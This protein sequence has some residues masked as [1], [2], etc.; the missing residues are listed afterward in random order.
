[1]N[2]Q[3][4]A[5][6]PSRAIL[7]LALMAA[8]ALGAGLPPAA[9]LSPPSSLACGLTQKTGCE[10]WT[11]RYNDTLNGQDWAYDALVSLDGS[12]LFVAGTSN[13]TTG[14]F[15]GYHA[16]TI[17][18]NTDDGTEAW[19]SRY[20]GAGRETDGGK[21]LGLSPD[22]SRLYVAG[23]TRFPNPLDTLDFLVLALDAGTGALLWESTFNA[24]SEPWDSHEDPT[25]F[26]ISPDGSRLFL[27]GGTTTAGS[28]DYLTVALDANDGSL[29]WSQQYDGPGYYARNL[30]PWYTDDDYPGAIGVSP[31][32]SR[33]FVTGGSLGTCHGRV[34]STTIAYD[35]TTGEQAWIARGPCL[36]EPI[37]S[38]DV[39]EL[40]GEDGF[41]ATYALDVHPDGSLVYVGGFTPLMALNAED[42][43][44]AWLLPLWG[45]DIPFFLKTNAAGTRVFFGDEEWLYAAEART[46][47]LLWATWV[48][49]TDP[50]AVSG[51]SFLRTTL[52]P[53]GS[54]IFAAAWNPFL[55]YRT[56]SFDA[57]TG[58]KKWSADHDG[59]PGWERAQAI[60]VSPDGD[61]V[62][63][64]GNAERRTDFSHSFMDIVTAAYDARMGIDRIAKA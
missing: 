36:P 49:A 34:Q 62:F 18:Y 53:D 52:S 24:A 11:A 44:L 28:W 13:S 1:M 64:T 8:S 2:R 3:R 19:V 25:G 12:L 29:L 40:L 57:L 51:S 9:S 42:G 60:A 54:R 47:T 5:G 4:T 48:R 61:R 56:M 31:N 14:N 63:V 27:T 41:D 22:G 20:H 7:L 6:E 46:G 35:A 26:A 32:G 45:T 58:S 10:T 15:T 50:D 21:F 55:G 39:D 38:P 43:T 16:L 59:R 33:V 30:N 17:A 23:W 37:W